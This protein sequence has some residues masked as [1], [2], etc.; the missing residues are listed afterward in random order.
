MIKDIISNTTIGESRHAIFE[1]GK[2]SEVF[3]EQRENER[4][5]GDI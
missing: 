2:L 5:V 4:M 1:N 3:V